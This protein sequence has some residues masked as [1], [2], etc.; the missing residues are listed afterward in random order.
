M[1]Y[2]KGKKNDDGKIVIDVIEE[3]R[4]DDLKSGTIGADAF[5]FDPFSILG[6][7]S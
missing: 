3:A 4:I 6:A 1:V 5:S 2:I 7:V